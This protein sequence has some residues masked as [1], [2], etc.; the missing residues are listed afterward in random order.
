[1]KKEI[2]PGDSVSVVICLGALFVRC[3]R[4]HDSSCVRFSSGFCGLPLSHFAMPFLDMSLKITYFRKQEHHL[5]VVSY[6]FVDVVIH[7][8]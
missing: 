8:S 5:A 4:L 6:P 2:P 7:I 1:M 3:A